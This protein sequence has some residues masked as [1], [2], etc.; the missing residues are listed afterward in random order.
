MRDLDSDSIISVVAPFYNEVQGI[1]SFV[2]ELEAEFQKIGYADRHELILVNDGSTD[3]SDHELDRIAAQYATKI[4]VIHFSRN[5]GHTSAVYAGL[6]YAQGLV[7]ILMDSDLQDDPA[8]FDLFLKKW[9]EGYDVV[10]AK[11]SSRQENILLRPFFWLF[12]RILMLMSETYIPLDAGNYALMDRRVIQLLLALPEKNLY[13][14]GLRAWIGFKQIGIPIPR[15]HRYDRSAR[16]GLKGKW[17]LAANAIFSFSYLPLFVFRLFGILALIVSLA[18][19]SYALYSKLISGRAVTAWTSNIISITFFGGLNLFGIGII[20]E[21]ISR[22][23][24]E[25]RTRPRYIIERTFGHR[26]D[27][28]SGQETNHR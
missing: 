14:P 18:L 23:Y 24:D 3:G 10:Y 21:Y 28:D 17:N 5:F 11:R 13:L 4:K 9:R 15:R 16:T 8:G 27:S 25:V 26:E 19:A 7:T 1:R 22:I 20:G 12:Y 2:E 6:A